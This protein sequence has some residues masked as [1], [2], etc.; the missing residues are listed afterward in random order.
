VETNRVVTSS[1]RV[2]LLESRMSREL[3]R[4]VEKHGGE[5]I[6]VPAVRECHELDSEAAARLIT[7]LS[8][9]AYDIAVFMTGVAVSMLFE[10]GERLGRRPDLVAGLRGVTTVCRGPKPTAALRGFGVVPTLTAR[11]SFTSAEVIDAFA[12][13]ELAGKRVLLFHYGERSDSLAETLVARR[14]ILDE[15]WLYR[16]QLP[17]DTSGLEQVVASIVDGDVDALAVTCQI[18]FRHLFQVAQRLGRERELIRALNEDVVVA[19]V[20]PTCHAILQVHGVEVQVVPEHP[21]MGPL[22]VTLMRHLERR[23]A[24]RVPVA[25]RE[26]FVGAPALARPPLSG[27]EDHP[28]EKD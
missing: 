3:A 23:S 18:Q 14:A 8:N 1:P 12:G 9:G 22:I 16:W 27:R 13:I 7:A 6:C 20:G 15:R 10:I 2:V 26:G 19:A 17:E 5:P 11:E 25:A 21:K 24:H 28:T 4:L